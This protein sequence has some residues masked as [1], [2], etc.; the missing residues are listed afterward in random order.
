MKNQNCPNV[1]RLIV[2]ILLDL[3]DLTLIPLGIDF[4]SPRRSALG[5]YHLLW[6]L[7]PLT[8]ALNY[9]TGSGSDLAVATHSIAF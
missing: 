8:R 7:G 4:N 6:R 9:R 3:I 2:C 5:W 1:D